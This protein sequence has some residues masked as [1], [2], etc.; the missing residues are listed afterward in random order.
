MFYEQGCSSVSLSDISRHAEIAIGNLTYYFKRKSDVIHA[1]ITQLLERCD[2]TA[3]ELLADYQEPHYTACMGTFLLMLTVCSDPHIGRFVN[4]VYED[5]DSRF[6]ISIYLERYY[7][8]Y[9]HMSE[10]KTILSDNQVHSLIVADAHAKFGILRDLL[11]RTEYN[12]TRKEILEMSETDYLLT[13]R[14]CSLGD[15]LALDAIQVCEEILSTRN[16]HGLKLLLVQSQEPPSTE[17]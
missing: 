6:L 4:E 16:M 15:Q 8:G 5:L 2:E 17:P 7:S 1:L 13:S 12:P 9:F 14:L 10:G 3:R 11:Q